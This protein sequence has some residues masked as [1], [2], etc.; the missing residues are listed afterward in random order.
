MF[1]TKCPSIMSTC[2]QSLPW[3]ILSAHSLP[4]FEK[5]ALRMDGAMIAGGHIVEDE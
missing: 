1:G 3:S 5:S 2:T 4:S